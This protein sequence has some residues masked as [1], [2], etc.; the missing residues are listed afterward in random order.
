MTLIG[1]NTHSSLRVRVGCVLI[2]IIA[3]ICIAYCSVGEHCLKARAD[4][5][6][7][8]LVSEI[9]P[10]DSIEKAEAAL[11]HVGANFSYDVFQSR[12]QAL[13]LNVG[14]GPYASVEICVNL[15]KLGRV[16]SVEVT[17]LYTS[18]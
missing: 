1:S 7:K 3:V 16:L 2:L 17:E 14:C 11:R 4:D 18:L 15:D 12:Y 13:I 6:R 8:Q 5:I 10:G 9:K